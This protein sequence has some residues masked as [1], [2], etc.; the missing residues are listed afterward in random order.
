MTEA[1]Q[2]LVSIV[3]VVSTLTC[4]ALFH[5]VCNLKDAQM[6]VQYSLIWE[7]IIYNFKLGQNTLEANKNICCAKGEATIDYSTVTRS[8]KKFH[9]VYKNINN[10]VSSVRLKTLE[11]ETKENLAN[12]TQRVSGEFSI[13][14]F[15]V[16]C[17]LHDLGKST[18]PHI[19]KI[20]QNFS[21]SLEK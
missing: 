16:I 5:C 20:L 8:F 18:I 19:T 9:S 13:S 14:Q 10:Q 11:S 6:N 21:L 15:N 1:V 12:S 3:M 17:H 2:A 4:C 7:F